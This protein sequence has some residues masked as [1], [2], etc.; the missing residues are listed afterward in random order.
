MKSNTCAEKKPLK[1]ITCLDL[2]SRELGA[3]V[4]AFAI[5]NIPIWFSAKGHSMFPFVIDGDTIMVS[6]YLDIPPEVGDIVAFLD[7]VTGNLIVHRIISLSRNQ[8]ITKGDSCFR[9]DTPQPISTILGFVSKVKSHKRIWSIFYYIIS[10]K[11]ITLFSRMGLFA[12]LGRIARASMKK[13]S[14]N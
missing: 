3:I 2:S 10:P 5:K 13:D 14:R 6:P 7:S 4:K 9:M 12:I 11:C 8:F 1:N